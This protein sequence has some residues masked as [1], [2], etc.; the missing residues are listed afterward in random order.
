MANISG[1]GGRLVVP[2]KDFLLPSTRFIQ[3]LV[4]RGLPSDLLD[5]LDS[6]TQRAYQD[7][8]ANYLAIE[9]YVNSLSGGASLRYATVVVAAS[10]SLNSSKLV[11][12]FVCTG[13]HDENTINSAIAALP[14]VGGRILFMEGTY[15][16]AGTT[17]H[18]TKPT[19]IEG[20]GWG[21]IF[22][23]N[24]NFQLF[25]GFADTEFC[26]FQFQSTAGASLFIDDSVTAHHHSCHGVWFNQQDNHTVAFEQVFGHYT[27]YDNL[28]SVIGTG[29][30][31][32]IVSENGLE[33][34]IF[35]NRLT[36][37]GLGTAILGGGG[38]N[39]GLLIA[40]NTVVSFV[41]GIVWN[42]DTDGSI[43]N[44]YIDCA[45]TASS[46]C[47]NPP[48]G[49]VLVAGNK[50]LGFTQYGIF[51]ESGVEIVDNSFQPG[52]GA[53]DL[54]RS[55]RSNLTGFN[56]AGFIHGNRGILGAHTATNG[57]TLVDNGGTANPRVIN[58]LL[59]PAC[60]TVI[61]DP[62]AIGI[63]NMDGSANN[64]NA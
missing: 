26:D 3:T 44:N 38:S 23:C 49:T 18:L 52:P 61:N 58:N 16:C 15:N 35:G 32:A 14:S 1:P 37:A 19:K 12:D 40:L 21:S 54:I 43:I 13:T 59:G 64:W 55:W 47:I 33:S 5:Q 6:I 10:D 34:R 39:N 36:G 4:G 20:Q 29:T 63:F 62:S 31:G 28:V 8:L 22:A 24:G 46:R 11:A 9:R 25:N 50:C 45:G 2:R 53:T 60:V 42:G 51:D 41:N 30:P 56:R 48:S 17:N 7:E 57:V 27:F